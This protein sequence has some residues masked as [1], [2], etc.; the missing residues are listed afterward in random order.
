MNYE[1]CCIFLS[2]V[3]VLFIGFSIG[4]RCLRIKLHNIIDSLI[5]QECIRRKKE[6]EYYINIGKRT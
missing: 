3:I 1:T 5:E 4:Y 2:Y 6:D